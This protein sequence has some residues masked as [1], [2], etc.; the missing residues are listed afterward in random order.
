MQLETGEFKNKTLITTVTSTYI[1][2]GG[3]LFV[4]CDRAIKSLH[5]EASE[6]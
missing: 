3:I 2:R 6:T 1:C 5:V 4:W